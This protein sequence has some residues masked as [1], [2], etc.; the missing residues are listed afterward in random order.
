MKSAAKQ[1]AAG[2][3][4]DRQARRDDV[5]DPRLDGARRAEVVERQAQQHSVGV[6]D[7]VDQLAAERERR[8]LRGRALVGRHQP[9][10]PGR[11]VEVRNRVDGEVAVSDRAAW[12]CRVP[13]LGRARGQTPADGLIALYGRVDVKQICHP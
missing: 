13:A 6:L 5:V 9:G 11:G 12:M 3:R 7:L 4:V 2:F 10:R 1:S 8:F